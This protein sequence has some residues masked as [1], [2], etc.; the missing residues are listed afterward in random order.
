MEL[1]VYNMRGE[2]I[3]DTGLDVAVFAGD[4]N[5]PVLREAYIAHNTNLRQG[6]ASTKTKGEV[7]GGGKKPYPQKGT[8]RARAGSIRSPL[9]VGGGTTFGPRSHTFAYKLSKKKKKLALISALR[10]KVKENRLFLLDSL[11]V[12]EGKTKEL[13][14]FL[15]NFM[16]ITNTS[17]KNLAITLQIDEK[18]CRASANI[19]NLKLTLA[20]NVSAY[21]IMY[22]DNIFFVQDSLQ[23]LIKRLK[24]E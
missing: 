13:A 24:N 19:P 20:S 1:N 21:H 16:E 15:K 10:L 4:A 11:V 17:E 9:W 7:S 14:S 3:G 5:E 8:G 18:L 12:V 22:H 2:K 6:T 23:A